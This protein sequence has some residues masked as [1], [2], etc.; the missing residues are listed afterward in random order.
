MNN[1]AERLRWLASFQRIAPSE[2]NKQPQSEKSVCVCLGPATVLQHVGQG[3]F[4][5]SRW[6]RVESGGEWRRVGEKR[7]PTIAA[8][9]KKGRRALCVNGRHRVGKEGLGEMDH[10][11]QQRV[12][13]C[14]W[15]T[16]KG[17]GLLRQM[18][19]RMQGNG[20]VAQ[21]CIHKKNPRDLS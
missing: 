10:S 13:V 7:E 20:G 12:C 11:T 4:V 9:R 19:T 18:M 15:R 3:V 8:G 21:G 1:G 2:P 6:R 17:G 5:F 16:G 14:V